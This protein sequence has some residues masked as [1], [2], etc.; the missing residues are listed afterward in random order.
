MYNVH[1]RLVILQPNLA[2]LW[3]TVESKIY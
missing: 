3:Y 2:A 1:I